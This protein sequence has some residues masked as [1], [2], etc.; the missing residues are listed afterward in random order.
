VREMCRMAFAQVGLNYEDH[1]KID[2]R[3]L[4]PAEVDVLLGD[5]TKAHTKL[6]WKAETTFE[7]LIAEMVD[8]DLKRHR[9]QM[10]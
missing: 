4:R 2:S 10:S 8:A 6:G 3:F 7:A 9:N 5:A 1:V